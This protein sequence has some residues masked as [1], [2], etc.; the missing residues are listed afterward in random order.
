MQFNTN[1]E[2]SSSG[3]VVLI[4]WF[5]WSSPEIIVEKHK[6]SQLS[7][8]LG[9]LYDEYNK[10]TSVKLKIVD[11]YLLYVFLTGVVQ[12]I[13]CCLVGTFPFNS[14]LSGFISCVS[15]FVLGGLYLN[16]FTRQT[17]V[18]KV[19]CL[20]QVVLRLSSSLSWK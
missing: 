15:C 17:T 13:Y 18:L 19:F 7:V 3:K 10:R 8:V 4:R 20:S 16:F 9:K 1:Y 14:F 11:S 12:F 6:M 5:I 2:R